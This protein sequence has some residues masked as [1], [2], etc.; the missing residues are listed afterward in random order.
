[1]TIERLPGTNSTP[2]FILHKLLENI[3]QIEGVVVVVKWDNK[4]YQCC[5][6]SQ[7]LSSLAMSSVCAQQMLARTI[8]N[9]ESAT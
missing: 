2:L 8:M 5:W 1:M 6:S 3:E 4:T 9:P 7:E